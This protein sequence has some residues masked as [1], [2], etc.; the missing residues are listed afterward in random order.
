MLQLL[1][2]H[3]MASGAEA[4]GGLLAGLL[5][6]ANLIKLAMAQASVIAVA[7]N[8]D[9]SRIVSGGGD[10]ILHLWEAKTGQ[11]IGALPG[12]KVRIES[13]A[14]SADGRLIVSAGGDTVRLWPAPRPGRTSSAPSSPET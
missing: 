8:P 10:G 9:G 13:V 14:Y 4:D 7:Y 11:P 3:R 5:H 2:A 1:A 6:R 12:D